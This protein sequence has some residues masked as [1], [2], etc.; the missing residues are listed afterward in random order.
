MSLYLKEPTMKEKKE[1]EEMVKEF[2]TSNDEY[3][4]EGLSNF[5]K[6]MEE[7]Y[8]EFLNLLE[9]NKHIDKINPNYANQTTF[10]LID[11]NGHVYGGI[12]LRHELKGKL[13]EIGGHVG[14]GIRPSERGK[15][16]GTLQLKLLIEKMNEMGIKNALITCRENN[17][18]SK[19]TMEK[20]IGYA[21]S[22]VP[23]MYEGIM[24]YR[25]WIDIKKEINKEKTKK[26]L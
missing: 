8:E 3:P 22:L 2:A 18:K 23:S 14:Y 17:I 21:D 11:E 26:S 4:F 6:V 25:Y 16:Y 13:F 7:S 5:K 15:G 19:K 10:V 20:F 24:E 12:N 1:I 9:I